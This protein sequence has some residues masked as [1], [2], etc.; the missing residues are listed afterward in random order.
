MRTEGP[1]G[2]QD[3]DFEGVG[4][5]PLPGDDDDED[6]SDEEAELQRVDKLPPLRCMLLQ[7]RICE[8]HQNGKD[9]HLRGLQIF[10]KDE[11]ARLKK[12]SEALSNSKSEKET[13]KPVQPSLPIRSGIKWENDDFFSVPNLR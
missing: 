6:L 10:A 12:R 9:T 8:N 3:I 1:R 7:V 2:W 11:G 13:V 5:S 4:D